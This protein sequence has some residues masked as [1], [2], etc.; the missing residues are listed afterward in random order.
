MRLLMLLC[1]CVIIIEEE[2]DVVVGEGEEDFNQMGKEEDVLVC[3]V[4]PLVGRHEIIQIVATTGHLLE[5][6]TNDII[7]MMTIM[8][9]I[10]MTIER[11]GGIIMA[12]ILRTTRVVMNV[13]AV[14]H[15]MQKVIGITRGDDTIIQKRGIDVIILEAVMVMNEGGVIVPQ[16]AVLRDVAMITK[17]TVTKEAKEK[18]AEKAK[19]D[20]ERTTTT[21]A[22]IIGTARGT[23]RNEGIERSIIDETKMIGTK[24]GRDDTVGARVVASYLEL[25]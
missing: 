13:L 9:D 2:V 7:M 20:S 10:E 5:N 4:P 15:L 23:T 16:V 14:H 8:T 11:I 18:T 21:T 1:N 25:E 6:A 19:V 22:A 24:N 17:T 3:R 12:T